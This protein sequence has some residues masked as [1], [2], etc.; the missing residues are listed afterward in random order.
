MAVYLGNKL[1]DA[2]Y[3]VSVYKDVPRYFARTLGGNTYGSLAAEDLQGLKSIRAYGFYNQDELETV[4][5]PETVEH[6]GKNAFGECDNI[7]W[8][9][10]LSSTPP[11]VENY[12]LPTG[13]GMIWYVPIGSLEAY[14]NDTYFSKYTSYLRER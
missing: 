14:Q 12:G 1:V 8:I 7:R 2:I 5:L 13:G 6:I 11:T 4:T 9:R 3:R 10:F